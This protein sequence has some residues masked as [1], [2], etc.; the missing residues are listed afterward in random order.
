MK[1]IAVN[2]PYFIP[3]RGYFR[4]LSETDLFVIY[5]DVQHIRRGFVHRNR[6]EVNGSLRWLTLPLD[7]QP[8]ETLIKDIRFARDAHRIFHERLLPFGRLPIALDIGDCH[9]LL[10]YLVETLQDCASLIGCRWNVMLSSQLEVDPEIRG[11]A[12][13]LEIC[14]RLGATDYVNAPGGRELYNPDAFEEAGVKLRFLP[15]W[16]GSYASIL[17]SYRDEVV[18]A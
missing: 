1:S 6:L 3:Y 16:T 18:A 8:R 4:L 5:D 12:R 7:H 15:E 2:Q 9:Y 10:T 14:R 13:I 17:Q 11:Q